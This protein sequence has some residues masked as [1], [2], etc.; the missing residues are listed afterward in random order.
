M[1]LNGL[2]IEKKPGRKKL[3]TPTIK[4][5]KFAKTFI[6]TGNQA[7]A[8]KEAGYTQASKPEDTATVKLLL[9]K[10]RHEM[11]KKF[12]KDAEKMYNNMK[13]LALESSSDTVRFNATKDILDRAGL[14]PIS[15]QEIESHRY[16]ST[17]SRIT[18]DLLERYRKEKQARVVEDVEE[19]SVE[20]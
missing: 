5:E 19:E 6:E 11:E 7:L 1:K 9:E 10:Y 18:H 16:V 4:Q 17:D 13:H 2:E 20:E 8:K 14:A 12:I 15:K 3:R